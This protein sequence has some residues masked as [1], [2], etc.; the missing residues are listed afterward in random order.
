MIYGYFYA[1]V[2]AWKQFI[3]H[4]ESSS[5]RVPE[6]VFLINNFDSTTVWE[7]RVDIST[8]MKLKPGAD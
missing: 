4:F 6:C 3:N 8:A 2:E 7:G 1:V 5:G